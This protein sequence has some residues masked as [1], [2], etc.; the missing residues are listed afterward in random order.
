M[1]NDVWK[2]IKY[3][4]FLLRV[5]T[6]LA[7]CQFGKSN[8][9]SFLK[10]TP[11]FCWIVRQFVHCKIM[12]DCWEARQKEKHT[13]ISIFGTISGNIYFFVD[14]WITM[15][16]CG[17]LTFFI[18]DNVDNFSWLWITCI[19]GNSARNCLKYHTIITY[20]YIHTIHTYINIISHH[21]IIILHSSQY[22]II[23]YSIL[24][25]I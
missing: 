6:V 8:G 23:Y 13:K 1:W 4:I 12:P 24:S 25:I 5:R 22:Y 10:N 20:H 15:W 14:M 16:K 7:T 9:G 21:I 2:L 11:H 17:K 19:W 3:V 18:V